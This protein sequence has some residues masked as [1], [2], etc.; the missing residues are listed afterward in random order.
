MRMY[1]IIEKKK[2]G[3]FLTDEEIRFLVNGTADN[4]I[5]DYQLS[6]F[7]M[8][9]YFKSM[10]D[11]EMTALT[12]HM[13]KSGDTADLS[14]LGKMTADKHS[15]GGV[16]DKTTLIAAPIAAALG[17][18]I[19]KMSG[20][21]LGHTG[22]TLDKLEAIPGFSVLM[23]PTDFIR[24]VND[25]GIAIIGQSGN[26][27]PAD[28]R[29]Y[30]L[31]DVTATVDSIPLIASSVMSK[32]LAAGSQ[33]I[34]LDVKYGSGAFMKTAEDA[35]ILAEKM[36]AIGSGAG[37]KTAAVIS[38]MESPLGRTVGNAVEVKEAI[39]VLN[40][41]GPEDLREIS[42]TL[43]ALMYSLASD[44]DFN[45]CLSLCE[46][47]ITDKSALKKF[48]DMVAYQGGDT[49]VVDNPDLLPTAKNTVDF[50]ANRA[51]YI[52]S[53]NAEQIGNASCVL[54]AGRIKKDDVIDPAAGIILNKKPGDYVEIGETIAV[55]HSNT[56]TQAAMEIMQRAVEISDSKPE[57][58]PLIY[59]IM[60]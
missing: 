45:D 40:G 41:G 5:P 11:A 47:T 51:G 49:K 29:F 3:G 44:T 4:T 42:F 53:M 39:E 55:L 52:K 17:C 20:R 14:A 12:L 48:R 10:T 19:A 1:D 15:T 22:G 59:E 60:T 25:I 31:R 37:R 9:V 7:L 8:A 26:M 43:A 30:A 2:R 56:D 21:G 32:K 33:N 24:Q 13:A 46:A 50:K 36:I 27:V 34:V 57:K 16:G 6:A 18:K 58:R 35:K 54:G 23:S 28:K 38:S